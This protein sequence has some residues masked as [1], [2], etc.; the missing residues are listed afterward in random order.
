[1][2]SAERAYVDGDLEAT[3][4]AL[5]RAHHAALADGEPVTAAAAAARLAM[6][7]LIDTG[8]MAPVRA[9]ISRADRLLDQQDETPVHAWAVLAHAEER[10]L[11]GDFEATRRY[12]EEA[13]AIGERQSALGPAAMARTALARTFI[14]EGDLERGTELLDEAASFLVGGELDDLTAGCLYCEIVCVWQSLARHDLAEEWTDAMSRFTERHGVGSIGGRCRVHRAELL[15]FRGDLRAAEDEALAACEELRPYMR[16][17]FGWPLSELGRIRLARGDLAGAERAFLESHPKGWEPQP[18]LA[19]LRL[20]QGDAHAALRSI[21]DALERPANAPSKELPP[22]NDLR[23]APLL[24]AQVEIAVAA[25]VVDAAQRACDELE[26]IAERIPGP[27]LETT[28]G[29][30]HGRVLFASGD[31]QAAADVLRQAAERW[32]ELDAPIEV[33]RTR[34]VLADV[35]DALGDGDAA[36]LERDAAK[37]LLPN[38]DRQD[39]AVFRCDG[40]FWMITFAD[41]SISVR[42]MKGLHLLARLLSDPGR[43]FHAIDLVSSDPSAARGLDDAGPMLDERA[44]ESYRRRLAEIEEDIAEARAFDDDARVALAEADREFLTRELSRAVGLG[45]SDRRSGS[46]LERARVSVTRAIRTAMGRITEHHAT[47]GEHLDRTI[48]T[49][50]YCAYMPDPIAVPRW[51]I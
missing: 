20:A 14:F 35:Y 24:D 10:F 30:A 37:T 25:G 13:I 49:G 16:R 48:R 40:D 1:M 45:G 21:T 3:L 39:A 28:A 46:A 31:A 5:E 15:R 7:L 36:S 4:D 8:L 9:W 26:A 50:T 22:N 12:A 51:R 23:R 17:E 43:E 2:A 34:S 47:L 32:S 19:L 11:S 18:G 42:D 44:V 29:A 33:A 27:A 6:H 41:R 38:V